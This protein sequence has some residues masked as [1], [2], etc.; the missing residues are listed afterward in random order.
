M[1]GLHE[2]REAG[3]DMDNGNS[4]AGCWRGFEGRVLTLAPTL[5][6]ILVLLFHRA[7]LPSR[8][9]SN[10][11]MIALTQAMIASDDSPAEAEAL[12]RR[13]IAYASDND[14]AWR[15]LGFALIAQDREVEA[16]AAWKNV[17]GM[18]QE[19]IQR[20]DQAR[21]N[22][23]FGKAIEGYT[24]AASLESTWLPWYRMGQ[25]YQTQQE[26]EKAAQAYQ[27]AVTLSSEN[28]DI[29]YELGQVN[30]S[31]KE[32]YVALQAFEQGLAANEGHQV[33]LSNLYYSIGRIKQASLSPPDLDGAWD[34]YERALALDDYASHLWQKGETYFRRGLI[35]TSQ[36]RWDEAVL[37][38]RKTLAFN[39]QHYYAHFFLA[40][41]LWREDEGEQAERILQQAID[42]DPTRKQ[43]YQLLGDFYRAE[44]EIAKA[45]A[46]YNKVLELD[47][48]DKKAREALKMLTDD[49]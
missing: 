44:G 31:R 42:L 38:Y 43:A 40:S 34:A 2:K 25:V 7:D 11:G 27:Q 41:A 9:W 13:A 29:W 45:T 4:Q 15:G 3:L 28:R 19:F 48:Q 32:W 37:E 21:W 49:N 39:K 10:R 26:W 20:G 14:S 8:M 46:M 33:G 35:L 12:L 16:I 5:I 23:Q 18:A 30:M 1:Q 24:L 22:N 17:V 6:V 47:P 36:K